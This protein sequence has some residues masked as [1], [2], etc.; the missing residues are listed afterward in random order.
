MNHALPPAL[1][2]CL[3]TFAAVSSAQETPPVDGM[4][5][6]RQSPLAV[7]PTTLW[8]A[9]TRALAVMKEQQVP[10]LVFVLPPADQR[11]DPKVAAAALADFR[12]KG[13]AGAPVAVGSARELLLVHIQLLRQV[14]VFDPGEDG[15]PGVGLGAAFGLAVPVV[16]EAAVCGAKPG[17]TMVLLGE[18]GKRRSGFAVDLADIAAVEA[19]LRP[20][21][22]PA[23]TLAARAANVPPAV[24]AA[25]DLALAPMRDERDPTE[26]QARFDAVMR[27]RRE[28]YAAAPALVTNDRATAALAERHDERPSLPWLL[29]FT[30]PL[31]TAVGVEWDPCPPCGM[32]AAPLPMRSALKLLAE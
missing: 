9:W 19:A 26:Q 4:V 16:A 25:V 12:Q 31:G 15:E 30:T 11:A 20:A 28:L 17:E 8:A 2:L 23:D 10:G 13:L 32:M 27:L 18:D 5:R 22:F 7:E 14:P 1:L 6:T 3:A 24:A 29:Q 21:L